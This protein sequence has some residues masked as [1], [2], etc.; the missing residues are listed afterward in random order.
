MGTLIQILT[1][2]VQEIQLRVTAEAAARGS[3][4]G[5]ELKLDRFEGSGHHRW[6][7]EIKATVGTKQAKLPRTLQ[8]AERQRDN[9]VDPAVVAAEHMERYDNEALRSFML[10]RSSDEPRAITQNCTGNDQDAWQ[11]VQNRFESNRLHRDPGFW[12]GQG[13]ASRTKQCADKP[14]RQERIMGAALQNEP[15]KNSTETELAT[16]LTLTSAPVR[17]VQS[18]E[19]AVGSIR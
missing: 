10:A 4:I 18:D 2:F 16:H 3:L 8:C 13:P 1:G 11:W 17:G 15:T 14:M 9:A 5:R 6:S 12:D 19:M 7:Y